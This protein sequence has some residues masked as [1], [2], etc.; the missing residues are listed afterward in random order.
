VPVDLTAFRIVQEALTNALK[1]GGPAARV[2]IAYSPA[3]VYLE[4]T[5]EGRGGAGHRVIRPN[6]IGH[7]LIGMRERVSVF[8]GDLTAGP[9]PEGGFRVAAHLPLSPV[10]S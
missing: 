3:E 4:V 2:T 1:H 10:S 5:D 7:G 6:A 9:R 8:D